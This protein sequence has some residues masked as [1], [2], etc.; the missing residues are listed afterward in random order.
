MLGKG[1]STLLGKTRSLRGPE[2]GCMARVLGFLLYCCVSVTGD[3][4]EV[5]FGI[6]GV[7]RQLHRELPL[8]CQLCLV[9]WMAEKQSS[10]YLGGSGR[11]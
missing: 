2:M 6:E 8:V 3:R 11:L 4:F 10:S 5:S 7:S 9:G 1:G